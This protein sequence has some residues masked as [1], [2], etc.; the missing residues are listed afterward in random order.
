MLTLIAI[1]Q[2][3][4]NLLSIVIVIDV[5]LSMLVAFNIINTSNDI[6]RGLHEG[7]S[8]FCD[9]LYRPIRR[10]L[11]SFGQLD[12]SPMVVLI[13]IRVGGVVLDRL[14]ISFATGGPL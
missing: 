2:M 6:V 12:F 9:P 4:L 11:P 5:I 10:V 13:L 14:Y 7:L 1:A 8:N 3:L